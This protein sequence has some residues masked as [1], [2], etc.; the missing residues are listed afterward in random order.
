LRTLFQFSSSFSDS[1]SSEED[2]EQDID[3]EIDTLPIRVSLGVPVVSDDPESNSALVTAVV[4]E[5]SL[6]HVAYNLSDDIRVGIPARSVRFVQSNECAEIR[7]SSCS[8]G[9]AMLCNEL[10]SLMPN[11]ASLMASG[12]LGS[13]LRLVGACNAN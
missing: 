12:N 6:A 3:P 9:I 10:T 4:A 5:M 7:A 2:C 13:A 1:E 11:S 8:A